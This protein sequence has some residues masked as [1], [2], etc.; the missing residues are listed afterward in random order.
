MASLALGQA[1]ISNGATPNV[2]LGINE[3]GSTNTPSSLTFGQASGTLSGFIGLAYTGVP[4]IT[5]LGDANSPGCQCEGWCVAANGTFGGLSDV[6]TG[7][8]LN[9]ITPVGFTSTSSTAVVTV[10]SNS[11]PL[12]IVQDYHPAAGAPNNVFEDTVTITNTG[13][14]TLN[15]VQYARVMD[16]DVPPTEFHEFISLHGNGAAN[17]ILT[18]DNGFVLPDPTVMGPSDIGG[19]GVNVDFSHCG[20]NDHGA[21]FLFDFGDLAAG[22][23]LTFSVFYG[24]APNEVDALT[25][26]A[27]VGAEVYA[28]GESTVHSVTGA[29]IAGSDTATFFFGFKGVG[30]TPIPPPGVPEPGGLVLLGSGLL[31]VAARVRKLMK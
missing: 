24:A 29:E 20:P 3:G 6:S 21:A 23:S 5:Y 13:G 7:G 15:H 4:G 10:T 1:V 18:H 30:G 31:T 16:F 28:L 25:A 17:L 14:D 8:V 11:L 27:A 22:N 2:I 12:T 19:C 26:L 9:G